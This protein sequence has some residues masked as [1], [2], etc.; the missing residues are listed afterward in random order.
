MR[1][2]FRKSVGVIGLGIIGSRVAAALREGGFKV[3]VWSRTPRTEPNFLGGP[4]EIAECADLIQLFVSDPGALF[5]VLDR[6]SDALTPHHLIICSATVGPEATVEAA[7]LVAERG[8]RFLDAPFTGSR[9]A[10]DQR[11]LVYYVGGDDADIQEAEPVLKASSKSIVR[12]GKVGQAAAV[13]IVTNMMAA[14]AVEALAEAYTLARQEGIDPETFSNALEQHGVRSPLHDQKLP[15]IIH[16]DFDTHFSVKHMF[17][18]VQLGIQMANAHGLDIPAT[19]GAAGMLYGC[20][21][22]GWQDLDFSA[23][24]KMYDLPESELMNLTPSAAVLAEIGKTEAPHPEPAKEPLEKDVKPATEATPGE[25]LDAGAK[26]AAR[27][28]TPVAEK[29]ESG[30]LMAVAETKVVPL[31][32]EPKI[33]GRKL[34]HTERAHAVLDDT[35]STATDVHVAAAE[36]PK[37]EEPKPAVTSAEEPRAQETGPAKPA[38]AAPEPQLSERQDPEVKDRTTEAIAEIPATSETTMNSQPATSGPA[39]ETK[40]SVEPP[41]IPA[42]PTA[43]APEEP[44]PDADQVNAELEEQPLDALEPEAT[45]EPAAPSDEIPEGKRPNPF[46]RFFGKR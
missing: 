20:M 19:T 5:D 9:I 1:R 44:A 13:K 25:T 32:D 34:A 28:D 14:T 37:L 43:A 6:M 7:K 46:L 12:I 15:K 22:S 18:D 26:P 17:K 16:G 29:P 23:V 45:T 11:G 42:T 35:K 39:A 33:E 8:A 40:R 2:K 31:P 41:P 21:N 27:I 3:H 4:T 36:K 24:V 30:L 10:A 38:A